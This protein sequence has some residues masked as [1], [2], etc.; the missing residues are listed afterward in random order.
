MTEGISRRGDDLL[1]IAQN[2][3]TMNRF[4]MLQAQQEQKELGAVGR[5]SDALNAAV[6]RAASGSTPSRPNIATGDGPKRRPE[7]PTPIITK[8]SSHNLLWYAWKQ[9]V[10]IGAN[11]DQYRIFSLDGSAYVDAVLPYVTWDWSAEMVE[12][13][14]YDTRGDYNAA[15]QTALLP[16]DGNSCILIIANS[17]V[18]LLFKKQFIGSTYSLG[19]VQYKRAATNERAYYVGTNTVR[20]IGLP[21]SLGSLVRAEIATSPYGSFPPSYSPFARVDSSHWYNPL[22]YGY[23]RARF[24]DI[25]AGALDLFQSQYQTTTD[26]T[27][28]AGPGA[29]AMFRNLDFA[30][31]VGTWEGSAGHWQQDAVYAFI[32]APELPAAT[33][34]ISALDPTGANAVD[35]RGAY[36]PGGGTDEQPIISQLEH[37]EAW[38]KAGKSKFLSTAPESP[39]D[40]PGER[41][42][43]SPTFFWDW[44]QPAYCREQLLAL[45]FTTADLVP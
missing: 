36:P 15:S 16:I 8:K 14:V 27:S 18:S 28:F 30:R 11:G 7:P 12:G 24:G 26:F 44:G 37:P 6:G 42:N 25:S 40:A 32:D 3:Q 22:K 29:Y 2:H 17:S 20:R 31:L 33:R 35:Y 39:Y 10:D 21:G 45:G 13:L 19:I 5:L 23:G 1:A 34:T 9:S 4:T 41:F 43:M 38:K